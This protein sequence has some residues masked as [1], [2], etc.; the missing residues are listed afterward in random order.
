MAFLSSNA[1]L[2]QN[3]LQP[4]PAWKVAAS[5]ARLYAN[6]QASMTGRERVYS[7]LPGIESFWGEGAGACEGCGLHHSGLRDGAAKRA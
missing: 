2:P 6:A 4:P 5:N 3:S 7:D 1:P